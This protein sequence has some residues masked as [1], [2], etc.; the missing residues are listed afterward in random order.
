MRTDTQAYRS[1]EHGYTVAAMFRCS[2]MG[3]VSVES[4]RKAKSGAVVNYSQNE[5]REG[6]N[7]STP[8]T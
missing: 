2:V 4:M 5:R 6:D 8:M 1:G 3:G 7:V